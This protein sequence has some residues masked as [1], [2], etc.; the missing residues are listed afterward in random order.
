[1][2]NYSPI[3]LGAKKKIIKGI[4]INEDEIVF[5][6]IENLTNDQKKRISKTRQ[7]F[8]NLTMDFS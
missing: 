1:M 6:N 4:S 7:T 2:K 8:Y 3:Q 5:S